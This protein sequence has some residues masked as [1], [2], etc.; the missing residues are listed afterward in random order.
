MSAQRQ[1]PFLTPQKNKQVCLHG[2]A[3]ML[4]QGKRF[5]VWGNF[6]ILKFILEEILLAE[7]E[8]HEFAFAVKNS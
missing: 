8:A 3:K 6:V 5:S 1:N 2:K 7:G 4:N